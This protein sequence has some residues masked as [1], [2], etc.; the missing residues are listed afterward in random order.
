MRIWDCVLVE[1]LVLKMGH[2]LRDSVLPTANTLATAMYYQGKDFLNP[3]AETL[4]SEMLVT[5]IPG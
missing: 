4:L 3:S 5:E 2:M 1:K